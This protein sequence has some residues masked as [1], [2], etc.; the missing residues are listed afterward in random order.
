[1]NSLCLLR[2][3]KIVFLSFWRICHSWLLQRQR[4]VIGF[5]YR[6][7]WSW[8]GWFQWGSTGEVGMILTASPSSFLEPS[9]AASLFARGLRRTMLRAS[10]GG[11]ETDKCSRFG[12]CAPISLD[13]PWGWGAASHWAPKC[14]Q[15][16]ADPSVL[17]DCRPSMIWIGLILVCI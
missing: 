13:L 11:S 8:W 10:V 14:C 3:V 17:K 1:M 4:S 9:N 7:H 15:N 5:N 12:I 2:S 6:N 16:I